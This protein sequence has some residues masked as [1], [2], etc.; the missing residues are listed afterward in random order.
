MS[1]T[2]RTDYFL[3]THWDSGD[4]GQ[5]ARQLERDLAAATR[6][7]DDHAAALG[8][9]QKELAAAREDP[10]FDAVVRDFP[11]LKVTEHR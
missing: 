8:M 10:R 7:S 6:Q 1:E 9:V 2:P 5:F 4:L 3:E 11:V